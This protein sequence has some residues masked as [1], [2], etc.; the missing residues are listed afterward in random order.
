MHKQWNII[1]RDFP[2]LGK[3][4][5]IKIPVKLTRDPGKDP[6][7]LYIHRVY[8]GCISLWL[9]LALPTSF[10]NNNFKKMKLK[11]FSCMTSI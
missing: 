10:N 11:F 2:G 8:I 1:S 3:N 5:G 6:L 9:S 7:V 4:P